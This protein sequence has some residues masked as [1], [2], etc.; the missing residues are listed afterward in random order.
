[1]GGRRRL[2]VGRRES[3]GKPDSQTRR[4]GAAQDRIAAGQGLCG[5]DRIR[6]CVG[7]AGDFTG[8]TAVFPR[9]PSRPHLVPIIARDVHKRPADSLCCHLASLPVSPRPAQ[10]GVGRREVG[11]KSPMPSD[12]RVPRLPPFPRSLGSVRPPLLAEPKAAVSQN[13]SLGKDSRSSRRCSRILGTA[14][15]GDHCSLTWTAWSAPQFGRRPW[16]APREVVPDV[17]QR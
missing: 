10:P 1:M 7:N 6:T 15:Y 9:L 14:A 5:R 8:R 12:Q 3:G 2:G 11:G 4:D 13:E 16:Q 17:A